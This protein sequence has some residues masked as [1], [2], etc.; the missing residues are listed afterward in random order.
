ML[1]EELGD[2]YATYEQLKKV[3]RLQGAQAR[4]PFEFQWK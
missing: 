2:G 3:Q 1:K 4:L